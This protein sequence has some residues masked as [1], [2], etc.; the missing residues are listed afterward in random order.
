MDN[1]ISLEINGIEVK[2]PAGTSILNA[3]KQVQVKIP[4][5]CFH[6]DLTPWAACGICIVRVIGSPKLLRACCTEV[7]P[8]M[9]I[10]TRSYGLL[11]SAACS[12]P[13]RVNASAKRA[14][15]S[16]VATCSWIGA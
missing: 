15:G 4:T 11:A 9:K 6:P 3:A 10:V 12:V 1:L 16:D 14:L 7:A 2:V 13:K 5:L 8:G